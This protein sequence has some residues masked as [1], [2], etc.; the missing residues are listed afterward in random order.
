MKKSSPGSVIN[1]INQYDLA[2]ICLIKILDQPHPNGIFLTI[3]D[4]L[5][6]FIY[7]YPKCNW[8]DRPKIIRM[9]MEY[10]DDVYLKSIILTSEKFEKFLL[11]LGKRE[12]FVHQFEV[13]L[14]GLHMLSIIVPKT[15]N[16]KSVFGFDDRCDIW[17]CWV[18]T[19]F[20]HDFGYPLEVIHDLLMAKSDLFK[21]LEFEE[22]SRDLEYIANKIHT[23]AELENVLIFAQSESSIKS[24]LNV[25]LFIKES[26][27]RILKISND[28]AD[29][30]LNKFKV[31]LDHG[32]ISSRLVIR[33]TIKEYMEDV[34]HWQDIDG[35]LKSREHKMLSYAISGIVAHNSEEIWNTGI[36]FAYNPYAVI[37]KIVDNIH[38]WNR[39]LFPDNRYPK[40][41]LRKFEKSD[42]SISVEI[43]ILNLEDPAVDMT[44]FHFFINEKKELFKAVAKSIK[45][46]V[47]FS[48]RVKYIDGDG[49]IYF[50]EVINF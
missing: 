2:L 29:E 11:A 43:G 9:I 25:D 19:A 28:Y 37:L 3:P 10:Y 18:Q 12:H 31:D 17:K 5:K 6:R 44:K 16:C 24:V 38:D 21:K 33:K 42:D 39:D 41:R 35:F 40:Y 13:M 30:L 49:N 46:P 50:N 32:F 27:V 8:L 22:T 45:S 47:G 7:S 14:I 15:P 23:N 20:G 36:P 48:L 4:P 34:D 1:T 26:I